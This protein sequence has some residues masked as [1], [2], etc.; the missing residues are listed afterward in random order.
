MSRAGTKGVSRAEREQQ[1]LAVAIEEFGRRGHARASVADIAARAGIS[2]PLV[3]GYFDSKDGLYLACLH[4]VGRLLVDAVAAARTHEGSPRHALDTLAAVFTAIDGCRYAW[5]LLYDPT[6]PPAGPVHDTAHH[7][8]GR[9]AG[10]GAAGSARL[11]A[12]A[13]HRDPLDHAFLDHLWQY[14]VTAVM[15]WWIDHPEQSPADM[16]ARSA[17]VLGA[18]G[19][20]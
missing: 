1:I 3:Y 10:M 11:L 2:K 7:Y 18:L 17:R 19:P 15:R 14:T 4:H 8:R 13:G 20:R 12:A 16:A 6:L 5:S 9:L